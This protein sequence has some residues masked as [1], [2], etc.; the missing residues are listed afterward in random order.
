MRFLKILALDVFIVLCSFA[1]A[2]GGRYVDGELLI[3]SYQSGLTIAA[4]MVLI[5]LGIGL[6]SWA[7]YTYYRHHLII[8]EL[9][10]QSTLVQDGPFAFSRNP[11]YISIWSIMFGAALIVGT[12]TGLFFGLLSVLWWSGWTYS[13]EEKSL[14]KK[15]GNE[16]IAYTQRVPRWFGF[17]RVRSPS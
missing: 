5:A 9:R 7:A 4:G 2:F 12:V 1:A 16:Y 11:L 6:R 17:P 8:L 13:I 15:F 3:R 10:S 14:R